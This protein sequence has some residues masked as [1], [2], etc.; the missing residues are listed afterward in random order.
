VMFLET[1]NHI[2]KVICALMLRVFDN[3]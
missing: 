2:R 3:D 1:N